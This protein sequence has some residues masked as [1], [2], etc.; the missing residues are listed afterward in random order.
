MTAPIWSPGATILPGTVVIPTVNAAAVAVPPTN[1]DFEAGNS[2]WALGT[3]WVIANIGSGAFAGVW[4]ATKTGVGASELLNN[5]VVAVTPGQYINATARIKASGAANNLGV[6]FIEWQTAGNVRISL[7]TGS[8]TFAS[9]G[10]YYTSTAIGNAPATAAFARVGISATVGAS[11]SITADS[12]TWSYLAPSSLAGVMYQATQAVVGTTGAA[13]PVWPTIVGN[14]IVDNTVTWTAVVTNRVVW[15]AHAI[16]ASGAAEPAWPVVVG[17][18]ISDGT[19]QWAAESRRVSDLKCPHSKEVTIGASKVF[20]TKQDIVRFSA[21]VNPLDWS[22]ANDAG[23]LPTGLQQNGSND[24]KVLS[25]YRGNLVDF[26]GSTFQM[27]Q[28]DPDPAQ[29]DMLDQIEGA[30]SIQHRAAQPV[31]NDLYYLA[32]N[33]VRSV[34]ISIASTNLAQGDVGKPVDSLV[35]ASLLASG[36]APLGFYYPSY[37][38]YWLCMRTAPPLIQGS[39]TGGGGGGSGTINLS[40]DAPDTIMGAT[41]NFTGYSLI[42]AS[43]LGSAWSIKSGAL[44][45]GLTLNRPLAQLLAFHYWP[46]LASRLLSSCRQS[47]VARQPPWQTRSM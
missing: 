2:G 29:M 37:G 31:G 47:A 36:G 40:G 38:Q 10:V 39:G 6:V 4:A 16:S 44:P 27:W 34:G 7:S 19:T 43:P 22:S 14:T 20:A 1:A 8:G 32:A 23:Y 3:G 17:G 46:A 21:T 42:G 41:Y 30:G 18:I 13:E 25:V 12:V 11:G 28:I 5:N 33:G 15:E 9:N 24:T 45:A 35:A 26:S